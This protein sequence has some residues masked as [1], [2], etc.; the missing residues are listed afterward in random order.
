MDYDNPVLDNLNG[1]DLSYLPA[2]NTYA[3]PDDQG[4]SLPFN[5]F[6][7]IADKLLGA[8][9]MNIDNATYGQRLTNAKNAAAIQAVTAPQGI[10]PPQINSFISRNV[11][12]LTT[13]LILA[14]LFYFGM[15]FARR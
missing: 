5:H 3:T 8:V 9:E 4:E 7:R 1:D 10:L 12:M 6:Q 11:G 13:L 2:V 15:L 14:G